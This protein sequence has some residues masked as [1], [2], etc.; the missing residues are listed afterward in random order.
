M[1]MALGA[2]IAGWHVGWVE[3]VRRISLGAMFGMRSARYR[4][5]LAIRPRSAG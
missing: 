1:Q 4:S 2:V 5:Y 3:L